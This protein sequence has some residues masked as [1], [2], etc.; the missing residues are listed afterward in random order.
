MDA[1]PGNGFFYMP[2]P[3][4]KPDSP[5]LSTVLS[6]FTSRS[7]CQRCGKAGPEVQGWREHDHEDKP[8]YIYVFLCKGCGK[9]LIGPHCRLYSQIMPNEPLPGVMN[10]CGDCPWRKLSRCT[11]PLA[12]FNGGPGLAIQIERPTNAHITCSPRRN[13]GWIQLYASPAT[14]CSGKTTRQ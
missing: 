3:K 9:V 7:K 6:P 10:I 4:L 5:R 1:T 13:S 14:G 8:E 11:S 12:K 2:D